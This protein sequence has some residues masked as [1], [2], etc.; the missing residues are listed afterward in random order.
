MLTHSTFDKEKTYEYLLSI[1]LSLDGFSFSI[2]PE[3]GNQ[4]IAYHDIRRKISS[5]ALIKRHFKEWVQK[6]AIFERPF[7][8]T[9]VIIHSENFALVPEECYGEEVKNRVSH[10]L[11][12]RKDEPEIAENSV[13]RMKARLVFTL[14]RGLYAEI[15]RM[16]GECEIVHPLK[17][18]IHNLPEPDTANG[19][20]LLMEESGFIIV[21]FNK[22]GLLAANWFK[23]TKP[24]DT[25]FYTLTMM[26]QTGLSPGNTTLFLSGPQNIAASVENTLGSCFANSEKLDKVISLGDTEQ[27]V[28]FCHLCHL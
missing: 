13:N 22:R 5:H 17:L 4:L 16:L 11:F 25:V 23:M 9:Y 20:A 26:R 12:E 28:S 19:V 6:E 2:K 3:N 27:E 1:Q 8:K 10:L 18:F 14:P 7:K 24:D 21:S 15:V